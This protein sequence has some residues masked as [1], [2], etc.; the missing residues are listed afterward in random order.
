MA[1]IWERKVR[2]HFRIKDF[3][4]DGVISRD[5]FQGLGKRFAEL[6]KLDPKQTKTLVKC[7]DDVSIFH[8]STFCNHAEPMAIFAC[9]VYIYLIPVIF[10]GLLICCSQYQ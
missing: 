4:E 2:T 9:R 3:D 5:D 10:L 7:F 8:P 1:Y 6:T